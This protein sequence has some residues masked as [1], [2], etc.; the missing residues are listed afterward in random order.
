LNGVVLT[1]TDA[2][3]TTRTTRSSI[4]GYYRFDEVA[5]GQTYII[6]VRSKRY[7]FA[8]QLISVTEDIARLNFTA[9]QAIG[10]LK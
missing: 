4:F 3:G 8:P 5:A 7:Q 6:G 1:L 9:S 10:S 2:N